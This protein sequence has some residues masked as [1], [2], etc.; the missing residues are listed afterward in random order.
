MR[1]RLAIVVLLGFLCLVVG[2][3]VT[4]LGSRSYISS[5]VIEVPAH[6]IDAKVL[7]AVAR[8]Q[9]VQ[10]V[11]VGV[12]TVCRKRSALSCPP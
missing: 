12:F 7:V 8:N 4:A 10:G 5:A 9:H 6:S 1:R 11:A 2:V 3:A